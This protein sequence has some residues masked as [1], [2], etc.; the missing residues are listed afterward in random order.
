MSFLPSDEPLCSEQGSPTVA[1]KIDARIRPIGEGF[2]VRRLLPSVARRRVGPVTFLD[3]MGPAQLPPGRGFDVRPHPHIGLATVTYLFE[4]EILHRDS[5]GSQQ[6]IEPGALNWMTAGRG[7]VHSERTPPA[8]R[9]RGPTMHALQLWVALP[10]MYE[11]IEPSFV[12]HGASELPAVELPGARL[13]VIIG[14]MLGAS[15]PVKTLSPLFYVEASL[16]SGAVL[17]IPDDHPERAIYVVS[18]AISID[19]ETHRDGV[20]LVLREKCAARISAVEPA[21]VM[22]LGGAPLEGERY[23]NWNFV[24]SSRERIDQ[25]REDWRAGRFPKVPGDEI[26]FVPLPD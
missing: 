17:A 23:M 13:R 14:S 12:H 21:R 3:H 8:Q 15:S 1:L 24:S 10:A 16:E 5:L 6:L 22:L 25:A 26:E 7:I 18:G 9:E 4:G 2:N 19:G 11:Q 20:L